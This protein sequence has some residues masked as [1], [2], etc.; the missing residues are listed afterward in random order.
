MRWWQMKKWNADL[1]RELRSDLEQ[2]S[3]SLSE[4]VTDALPFGG[5]HHNAPPARENRGTD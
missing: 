1:E 3:F 5:T 4:R 2:D